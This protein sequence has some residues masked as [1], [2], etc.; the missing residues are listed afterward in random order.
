MC[1]PHKEKQ[2]GPPAST[3]IT[4]RKDTVPFKELM[5]KYR[6]NNPQD[7]RENLSFY[8][9]QG[10]QIP[11]E[12]TVKELKKQLRRPNINGVVLFTDMNQEVESHIEN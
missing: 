7:K 8:L 1:H 12:Q 4:Y 5:V 6:Q 9:S 3:I 10:F 2:E 11:E